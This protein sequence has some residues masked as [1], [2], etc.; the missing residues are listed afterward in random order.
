MKANAFKGILLAAAIIVV[1]SAVFAAL[2]FLIGFITDLVTQTVFLRACL[3]A[4]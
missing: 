1:Y 3:T 4:D 2:W